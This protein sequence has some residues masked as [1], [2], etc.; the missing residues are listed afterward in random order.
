[1]D[2][3]QV[4]RTIAGTG[5]R[6]ALAGLL[7]GAAALGTQRLAAAKKRN[8]KKRKKCPKRDACPQRACCACRAGV[9]DPT[10]CG[11]IEPGEDSD[12]TAERCRTFCQ[13]TDGIVATFP[14]EPDT[15][16][17]CDTDDVCRRVPCP[18]A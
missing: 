16:V 13:D 5:R 4:T 8:K 18:L 15:S 17:L 11:T 2:I 1:M 7:A 12:E 14:P 3:D 6:Q 10:R 9:G